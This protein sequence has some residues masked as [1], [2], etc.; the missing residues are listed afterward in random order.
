MQHLFFHKRFRYFFSLVLSVVIFSIPFCEVYAVSIPSASSVANKLEKRYNV[1]LE[2]IKNAGQGFNVSNTKKNVPE[3]S[4]FFSTPDP[5]SGQKI[6]AR[7]LPVYFSN[8]EE[9]LYYTWYLKRKDCNAGTCDYNGDGRYDS[10][11][12][13]I[14]AA[15]LLVQNGFDSVEAG[16]VYAG[17]TD[18]DGYKARFGGDNKEG[19]ND[20]CGVYD[21]RSGEVYELADA[22]LT[23]FF[24]PAGK[25]PVCMGGEVGIDPV[26]SQFDPT[27]T[28]SISSFSQ[29]PVDCFV[30]GGCFPVGAPVCKGGS[31]PTCADGIPCCVDDPISSTSCS[32]L[33]VDC[34]AVPS[35]KITNLCKHVFADSPVGSTGDGVFGVNEERFWKTNPDDPSTANNGNKDEAN[36]VGFGLSDFTWTYFAGDQL[37]VAVEG[38]SLIPT[39]HDDSSYLVMW[40]F[41]KNR[42]M[43][44]LVGA[45]TGE[46]VQDVKG[47]AVTF[48]STDLDPNDCIELNLIDPTE[49]GQPTNLD[50]SV[51][52]SPTSFVN[53]ES[54][55]ASGDVAFVQATINNATRENASIR[56]R[57]TIELSDN[58][59]FSNPNNIT[60]G[61][62]AAELVNRVEGNG[63]DQLVFKL[64]MKAALLGALSG[65]SGYIRFKVRVEEDVDGGG[66]RKG[67]SDVIAKFTS[68]GKRIVAYRVDPVVVGANTHVKLHNSPILK[69]NVICED[70]PLERSLCRVV[71][72]EVVGVKIDGAGL[73][74]FSWQ[75]NRNP[76]TC[77]KQFTSPDCLDGVQGNVAFL[78]ITGEVG[79]S[80]DVSVT[81]NTVSGETI[82]ISRVFHVVEPFV[83]IVSDNNSVAWPKLLGYYRDVLGKADPSICPSGMCPDY[84]DNAIQAF[85]DTSVTLKAVY[86]PG[87][88][89]SAS[90]LEKVW[91]L[92]DDIIAETAPNT[93]A[94][95]TNK[96]AGATYD[97]SFKAFSVQSDL[98]RRA[99]HDVWGISPLDSTEI[100]FNG[101]AQIEVQSNLLAA[102]S[103]KGIK[104]YYALL[105]SYV[106]ETM[107]LTIRMFLVGML[108][109]FCARFIGSLSSR[110]TISYEVTS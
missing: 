19:K 34:S 31:I 52:V 99:L 95:P 26:M 81:A 57:W 80:Y 89:G 10:R 65:R 54:A 107:L 17:D 35:A 11:D 38:T 42:C 71:K 87:F 90:G 73:K 59:R 48:P 108:L 94:F 16:M 24:C 106:P 64:D 77:T 2:S 85:Q 6:T 70:T 43:P 46:Y 84:S 4:L 110:H 13:R 62:V 83:T 45:N 53:D 86:V 36:V 1:N 93:I 91:M 68:I 105:S 56:Y 82:T 49:G 50:V 88:L 60:A 66:V 101:S 37:G 100:R 109:L 76:L 79:D 30:P 7:A 8:S 33:L 61:A 96:A 21:T 103:E 3:V 74:D 39:K 51:T 20:Y 18:D 97:V 14:E 92:D 12:W 25:F 15:T 55:D 69:D 44:S 27:M 40:A 58:P 104:K 75:V 67:K 102:G 32:S 5:K 29:T 78:P 28:S 41:P 23:T 22:G 9:S 47:Y 63:L 98:M 72:N